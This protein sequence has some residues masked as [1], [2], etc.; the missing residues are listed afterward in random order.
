MMR[1]TF[2]LV[3]IACGGLTLA[4]C[5]KKDDN[6]GSTASAASTAAATATATAADTATAAPT[7]TAT[8][9]PADSAAPA[10][11]GSAVPADTA[12]PVVNPVLPQRGIEDCCAALAAAATGGRGRAAK[13]R[14]FRALEVCPG[15]AAQVR[16]GRA[17]RAAALTQVRSAL[18]GHPIP[19]ACR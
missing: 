3:L 18:T 12:A 5:G 8:A 10:A 16:Q 9:A 11:S 17:T 7:A 1:A 13:N 15:I 2:A 4:G 6:A 14:S 19:A